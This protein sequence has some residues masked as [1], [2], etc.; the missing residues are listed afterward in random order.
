MQQND[1]RAGVGAG[2][3]NMQRDAVARALREAHIGKIS[4][5]A[6]YAGVL[7]A[8]SVTN[9]ASIASRVS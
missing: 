5:G 4:H 8:A 9:S 2:F 3:C 1:E 6:F 7:C